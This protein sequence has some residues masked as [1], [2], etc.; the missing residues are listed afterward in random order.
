MAAVAEPHARGA[1][2]ARFADEPQRGTRRHPVFGKVHRIAVACEDAE[3]GLEA[4]VHLFEVM[5]VEPVVG[6]KHKERVIGVGRARFNHRV[7]QVGER[8][9]FADL[10]RVKPLDHV[11]AQ[12]AHHLRGGIGAVV[13]HDPDVD[14]VGRVGLQLDVADQIA[15]HRLLV[16][17]RD[18]HGV[19]FV[20][21]GRREDD[22]FGEQRDENAQG[23]IAHAHAAYDDE[24][25]V[26]NRQ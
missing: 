22:R 13:R 15:D 6:V 17:R 18:Q 12:V 10:R 25:D 5:L 23:L 1:Q 26:K 3:A 4:L 14:E 21:W 2:E 16:A 7:E 9:T 19:A 20:H 8:V 24:Q 11:A